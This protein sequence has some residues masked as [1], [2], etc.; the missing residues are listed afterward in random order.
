M[1]ISRNQ[2]AREYVKSLAGVEKVTIVEAEKRIKDICNMIVLELKKGN[3][4]R[5]R[6]F[7]RFEVKKR[8]AFRGTHPQTGEPIEYKASKMLYITPTKTLK[9]YLKSEN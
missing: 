7:V 2:L 6:K 5:L 3:S 9:R 4:I 8:K 1:I